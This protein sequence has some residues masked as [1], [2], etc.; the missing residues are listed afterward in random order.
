MNVELTYFKPSGEYYAGDSYE[1]KCEHV[2]QI[3]DEVKAMKASGKQLPGLMGT[4]SGPIL[5]NPVGHPMGYL[6]L[7]P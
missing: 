5:I 4:W 3:F 1:T 7:I 6:G 2:F